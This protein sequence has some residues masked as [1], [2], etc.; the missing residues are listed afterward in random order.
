MAAWLAQ[1][2]ATLSI[3]SLQKQKLTQ[4]YIH[5]HLEVQI[6]KLK[7]LQGKSVTLMWNG[8]IESENGITHVYHTSNS[9]ECMQVNGGTLQL[10][11]IYKKLYFLL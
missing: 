11:A 7:N 3:P 6:M 4:H 10:H 2:H 5:V 8:E 9:R 1:S